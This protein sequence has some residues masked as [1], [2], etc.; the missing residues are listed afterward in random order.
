MFRLSILLIA[1]VTLQGCLNPR[2]TLNEKSPSY[3]GQPA[4]ILFNQMGLPNSEGE[5]AG[6]RYYLWSYQNSGSLTL[7]QYNTANSSGSYNTY[8]GG[9]G[10]YSGTTGYT[11]YQT[12]NYNYQC[13]IRAF[14]NR[15]DIITKFDMDGNVGGCNPLVR[16][17]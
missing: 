1:L 5:V 12:T 9:Y 15:N 14:V 17:M 3:I 2:D 16:R 13:V 6:R 7:P 11:T 8:G 10:T 4:E